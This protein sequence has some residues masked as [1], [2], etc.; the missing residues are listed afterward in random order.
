MSVIAL[1]VLAA[2]IVHD[3]IVRQLLRQ[4]PGSAGAFTAAGQSAP[5]Y[6]CDLR[7]SGTQPSSLPLPSSRTSTCCGSH[8]SSFTCALWSHYYDCGAA[9]LLHCA[10]SL[11]VTK[12]CECCTA[13]SLQVLDR[14]HCHWG[15]HLTAQAAHS[16][17]CRKQCNVKGLVSPDPVAHR[18]H[19]SAD[20]CNTQC[21][22]AKKAMQEKHGK[23][24]DLPVMSQ[25]ALTLSSEV[26]TWTCSL[27]CIWAGAAAAASAADISLVAAASDTAWRSTSAINEQVVLAASHM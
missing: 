8:P 11:H 7:Y 12:L 1:P 24:H 9:G 15:V 4:G 6:E 26:M 19:S 13:S 16:S 20:T 21:S 22:Y 27:I 23:Q 5:P 2:L 25:H 14:M 17:V 18:S 3:L 10:A